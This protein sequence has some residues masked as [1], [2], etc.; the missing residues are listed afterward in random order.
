MSA[1][2][3]CH[4]EVP[5]IRMVTNDQILIEIIVV[6]VTGPGTLQLQC[7]HICV[8][9]MYSSEGMDGFALSALRPRMIS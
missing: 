7:I 8:L 5:M 3:R 2:S 6:I 4:E 9:Q 1:T